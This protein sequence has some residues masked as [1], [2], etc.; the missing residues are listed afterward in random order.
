MIH[1]QLWCTTS[2]LTSVP[3]L[4]SFQNSENNRGFAIRERRAKVGE[5]VQKFCANKSRKRRGQ[6]RRGRGPAV[7][8]SAF[9]RELLFKARHGLRQRKRKKKT[10]LKVD[11]LF[12]I[13]L[14]SS[15]LA[16]SPYHL[17]NCFAAVSAHGNICR[18][19]LIPFKFH[20]FLF[21]DGK[22]LMNGGKSGDNRVRSDTH[23]IILFYNRKKLESEIGIKLIF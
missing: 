12:S 16:L 6:C 18:E 4:L 2:H 21:M 9:N 14:L 3:T 1:T 17:V 15:F 13:G 10:T 23:S 8:E 7:A 5:V 11:Q 22:Y 20:L 19:M